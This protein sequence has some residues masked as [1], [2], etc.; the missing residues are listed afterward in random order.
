MGITA[1]LL[2]EWS[3]NLLNIVK[4]AVRA[5]SHQDDGMITLKTRVV[6][7]MTIGNK[8]HKLV[9]M[10]QI[11]DNGPGIAKKLKE[12]IF[13]PMV[14]GT[15]GG[16][17]VGLSISQALISKHGGFIECESQKGETVFT[18]WIPLEESN[19]SAWWYLGYWW[20]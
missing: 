9:T 15:Q 5:L 4:N 8:R 13:F 10:I 6:R 12:K 17:G 20:W 3:F 2:L 16:V 11:I 19:E 1:S 14:S 7:Q 18:V